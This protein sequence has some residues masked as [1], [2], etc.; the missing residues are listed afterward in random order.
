MTE[1]VEKTKI[2]IEANSI[3]EA[4]NKA[5]EELGSSVSQLS[6]QVDRT[7][8]RTSSG[9]SVGK[10]SIRVFVFVKG[11]DEVSE[12][13]SKKKNK[14]SKQERY[15]KTKIESDGGI[16]GVT[17]LQE[18]INKMGITSEVSYLIKDITREHMITLCVKS[19]EGGRLVGRR[20]SS[21]RKILYIL[22]MAKVKE[23]PQCEFFIDILSENGG[24]RDRKK[25][26]EK[27]KYSEKRHRLNDNDIQKMKKMARKVGLKVSE[28]Q[29]AVVITKTL[30]NFE[31]KIIHEVI[32][33]IDGIATES[34]N[35]SEG[36]R[37]IRIFPLLEVKEETEELNI[38][39]ADVTITPENSE[40]T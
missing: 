10:S 5:A 27:N 11:E 20:G 28:D 18:L 22:D 35:D 19:T 16:W 26:N 40:E 29:K 12:H 36:I 33:K 8:F 9:K 1:S 2:S 17:F 37:R 4:L 24:R 34:F 21:L 39:V 38:D 30:N 6:Y 3:N 7:H 23:Y 31:R 14:V 25:R 32:S 13:S 15:N